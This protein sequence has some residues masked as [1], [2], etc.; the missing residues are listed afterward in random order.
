MQE[1][2][3]RQQ[4]LIDKLQSRIYS[5]QEMEQE[6]KRLRKL[7]GF[8][9]KTNYSTITARVIAHIKNGTTQIIVLNKGKESGVKRNQVVIYYSGLVG[10]I[11]ESYRGV[12]RAILITDLSSSVT[13]KVLRTGDSGLLKG[14]GRSDSC[15]LLYLNPDSNVN[16]GDKVITSGMGQIF[17]SNIPIGEVTGVEWDSSQLYKKA[18][19]KLFTNLNKLEEVLVILK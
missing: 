13:A 9:K 10:R 17:P 1:K 4:E 14:N 2:I 3:K 8:R 6:L 12:S 16:T 5:Y 7:L 11:I 18:K 19:V 15:Y